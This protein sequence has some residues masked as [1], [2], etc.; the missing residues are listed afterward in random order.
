MPRCRDRLKSHPRNNVQPAL[1]Y[2]IIAGIRSSRNQNGACP[3]PTGSFT[4]PG[5]RIPH[6]QS[7][8]SPSPARRHAMSGC[9]YWRLMHLPPIWH[10]GATRDT[11]QA[12]SES[13]SQKLTY[14]LPQDYYVRPSFRTFTHVMGGVAKLLDHPHASNIDRM[15]PTLWNLLHGIHDPCRRDSTRRRRKQQAM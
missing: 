3:L 10:R 9:G 4:P 14:P 13:E 8:L 11:L 5:P 12:R 7:P 15:P 2:G 6:N 1:G